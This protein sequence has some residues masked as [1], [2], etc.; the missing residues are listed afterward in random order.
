MEAYR[1]VHDMHVCVAVGLVGGGG[2]P[3]PGSWLLRVRDQLRAPTLDYEYGY[4]LCDFLCVSNSN[5]HRICTV[6]K[7]R[8]IISQIITVDI[9]VP[10][11]KALVRAESI[12]Q[13]EVF[14]VA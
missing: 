10:L 12:N 14:K 8:Q 11:F 4:L 1:R 3:P 2:S 13:S 5:L 9:V 7:I 6:S